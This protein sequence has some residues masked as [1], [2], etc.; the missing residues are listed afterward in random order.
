MTG[1]FSKD[2]ICNTCKN[3][4]GKI[5]TAPISKKKVPVYSCK[6]Y[7]LAEGYCYDKNI[8]SNYEREE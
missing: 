3:K 1:M 4:M 2:K 7:P 8:C 6:N 5:F